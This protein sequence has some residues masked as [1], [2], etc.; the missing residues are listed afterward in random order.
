MRKS[1]LFL[2]ADKAKEQ[3][4]CEP[5]CEAVANKDRMTEID[6][7]SVVKDAWTAYDASREPIAVTDI[8][9]KVSTN[10]V[11]KLQFEDQRF[12]VAKLSWFG[13]YE[14][15]KE[16]HTIINVLGHSLTGQ[17][18]NFLA[19]SITIES[20]G[21]EEVYTYRCTRKGK[22]VWVVFYHP[23]QVQ[24]M[25]PRRLDDRHILK[26]GEQI[27]LFHRACADVADQLPP[28][29]KTLHTDVMDL[30]ALLEE[31]SG[32]RR[33]IDLVRRQCDSFFENIEVLGYQNFKM[34]PVFVD[35]NIGNFSITP[36]G[37]LF[38]R[39][40]YDWFRVCTRTVDFYFMSRVV[41]DIGDRT[42][43]SYLAD[44][45]MEPR[46]IR[47][48]R[49]YHAIFPLDEAEVRF[50]KEAYRFFILNYVVKYGW[51]FFRASYAAQLQNEAFN[52]Y[53]PQIDTVFDAEKLLRALNI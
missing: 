52:L 28:S 42:V 37:D 41:S 20:P 49:A 19:R 31:Q 21:G 24:E 23:I 34:I 11:Y 17:F 46:F 33:E 2:S 30:V 53:L 47:F 35:W 4:Y 10:H 9:A 48:L 38:S 25:M 16:D 14:H 50:I 12:I 32:S 44:P 40:D 18:A 3:V 39:W 15:F 45:M 36:E 7:Q 29:S 1:V 6:F 43:F 22:D 26:L 5:L 8:S 13:K 27:A 51:Q